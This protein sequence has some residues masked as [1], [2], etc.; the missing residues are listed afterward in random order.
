MQTA[1]N[2]PVDEK[3]VSLQLLS[4]SYFFI[5]K[6][7]TLLLTTWISK[8]GCLQMVL[9]KGT[10]AKKDIYCHQKEKTLLLTT[11]ISW[12]ECR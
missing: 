11:W 9:V 8:S 1:K 2:A 4:D 12:S 10:R 6:E 7:K 5:P 3:A